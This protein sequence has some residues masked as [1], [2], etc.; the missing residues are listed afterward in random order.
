MFGSILP[1]SEEPIRPSLAGIFRPSNAFAMLSEQHF[2][3]YGI[4][5]TCALA[6]MLVIFIL[7]RGYVK[8]GTKDPERNFLHSNKGSYGTAGWMSEKDMKEALQVTKNVR[9]I[10]G[11]ILGE[12]NGN[13][14]AMH[15]RIFEDTPQGKSSNRNVAVYGAAGTGKSRAYARNLIFQ[16]VKRGESLVITDPSS[17]LYCSMAEYLRGNG[18]D[19]KMFNLVVPAHSDSWNCLREIEGDDPELMAQLFADVVVKNTLL[20]GRIDPFWDTNSMALL[21]AMVLYVGLVYPEENRNIGEMYR[22]VATL[23]PD[24]LR[25]RFARLPADNPARMSFYSFE[26]ATDNVQA[27][28]LTGLVV[29]LRIFQIEAFKQIT[30]HSDIDLELPGQKP[31]A[32]FCITS[33]Q[34]SA[35]D[36]MSSLFVSFLFIKLVGV[37]QRSPGGI[38]P[39]PVHLLADELAN[40]GAIPDLNRKISSVRKYGI[41]MSVIFQNLAQMKNRYPDDVWLEIIGNCDTQLFLGCTDSLT[42]KFISERSGEITIGVESRAKELS[43]IRVTDWT[44]AHRESSSVGKRFLLTPDEVLRLREDEALVIIRGRN[45]LKVKKFDYSKHPEA[46]SRWLRDCAV[47]DHI[48]SWKRPQRPT[49]ITVRPTRPSSPTGQHGDSGFRDGYNRGYN[50]DDSSLVNT[51]PTTPLTPTNPFPGREVFRRDA[52]RT[53]KDATLDI[54]TGRDGIPEVQP[55]FGSTLPGYVET[56]DDL[57]EFWS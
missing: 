57:D 51:S 39:V 36:F 24:E 48:P 26:K 29:K 25:T 14:V 40:I 52:E 4:L 17:E 13:I 44:P 50:R 12:L 3:L 55:H 33:E 10:P 30:S 35:F 23:S 9:A 54:D 18:Y 34:S 32:Y 53:G 28:V 1:S 56:C 49:R 27:S 41:S 5:S 16:C 21:T 11:T 19:V 47:Q 20:G 15:E 46:K 7:K 45:I 2:N 38:L 37:A 42:A 43:T 6:V 22:L 8:R 31:C